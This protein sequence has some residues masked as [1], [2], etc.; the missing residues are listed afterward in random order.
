MQSAT[1]GLTQQPSPEASAELVSSSLLHS[2]KVT[3]EEVE[4]Y[5]VSLELRVKCEE[6]YVRS[7]RHSLDK[8]RD[9]E[10]KLD[11]RISRV[12]SNASGTANLPSMRKAW[13]E[14]QESTEKEVAA[15]LYFVE[16]LKTTSIQP[17]RNFHDAQ[18]RIRR[19]V[20]EDL[21]HSL[22]DY[23]EA[24]HS[25]HKRIRKNY[26]RACE[27][28][29]TLKQQQQAV[30]DQRTLLSPPA[31]SA[32]ATV[33]PPPSVEPRQPPG[34]RSPESN[35]SR[36]GK[37]NGSDGGRRSES[38]PRGALE[39]RSST[40]E[41]RIEKA[42]SIIR[43]KTMGH[44]RTTSAQSSSEDVEKVLATSPP[45]A[46][47]RR[48]AA[49]PGAFFEALKSKD[50]WE[51]ARK[52]AAKKTNALITKMREAS[53]KG[54]GTSEREVAQLN[55]LLSQANNEGGAGSA[56][57]LQRSS[58]VAQKHAQFAQSM[59]MKLTKAKR[60][61]S[62]ADKAYRRC[63]FDLETLALRREKTLQAART[64]VLD[65]RQELF[66]LCSHAW[67]FLVQGKQYVGSND[68]SLAHHAELML[69][70]LRQPG[71]LEHEL[72]VVD[73]RLPVLNSGED[74]P[75]PYINYWHG[76]CKSLLFGVSLVDYDFARS[77]HH[78]APQ[79]GPA[80]VEPPLIVSKCIDFIE[81][82]ALEQP[83]IY[84]T[85]AKHTTVQELVA[86][87]E[88]DEARFAFDPE[89]DDPAAVA[90]VLKQWLRELPT[91]VLAMPWEER[92]KLTHSLDEQLQNGFATLKGRIRRLQP[93]HQVTL[94]VIIEHL[95]RVAARAD[96]N[97][98]TA[99]NLSVVFGPP[100][101]SE[102]DRGGPGS[103]GETLSL[104]AAMEEDRVCEY[105]ITYCDDIFALDKSGAPIVNWNPL[106]TG[107]PLQMEVPQASRR[108]TPQS[109]S[110]ERSPVSD[111]ASALAAARLT[112]ESERLLVP[113]GTSASL[114]RSNA[115]AVSSS[116]GFSNAAVATGGPALSTGSPPSTWSSPSAAEMYEADGHYA[117]G[118]HPYA[119]HP[120]LD[121]AHEEGWSSKIPRL[122]RD[123][124]AISD[125][126]PVK[127]T[128]SSVSHS[129]T[130]ATTALPRTTTTTTT[131]L[132]PQANPYLVSGT[133]QSAPV[134]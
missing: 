113:A 110:A 129:P 80:P 97:K 25:Q 4:S 47:N 43:K 51:S 90:G 111:T 6:D 130:T 31:S 59:A 125:L 71:I 63:I 86:A 14:L 84:R 85:S 11:I 27:L 107:G 45:D 3:L 92:L 29:E 55:A 133:T 2:F 49:G 58:S 50:A 1:V 23:D 34:L 75:A 83:G 48:S 104:A 100:L 36:T 62:E 132:P 91:P 99:K 106:S 28:V 38:G 127:S 40:P 117:E 9:Q 67:L 77:Q 44:N 13:K 26:E 17:L 114:R 54:D 102:T 124:S 39:E 94:R 70:N 79:L 134:A 35:S 15:R 119:A 5:V 46:S 56:A 8:S 123:D 121:A 81:Q 42:A 52:E 41:P 76:E 128:V 32:T 22:A 109:L 73:S 115:L 16:N 74:G 30:E 122:P 88:K 103:D 69:D 72:A 65:C 57:S 101:L 105:L 112:P 66:H 12:A 78:R 96:V 33:P 95:A 131:S 126:G 60:E 61:A 64:S 98:M 89:H 120:D 18:D 82:H 53:D 118:N 21:K 24:R 116:A 7:L 87:I 108:G 37:D 20:K 68:A 19:R 93:V 10:T